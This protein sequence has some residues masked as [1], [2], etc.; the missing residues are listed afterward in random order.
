MVVCQTIRQVISCRRMTTW[1]DVRI[2][3][4][5]TMW[6][7]S[8]DVKEPSS[9]WKLK[10]L[11]ADHSPCRCLQYMVQIE[12]PSWVSVHLVRHGKFAEHFVSSQRNDR[13]SKYDRN[14]ARQDSPVIH[15]IMLNAPEVIFIS[16]R[17]LCMQA[18]TETRDIWAKVV[19]EIG[20]IDPEVE[21]LCHPPCWWYGGRCP[22]MKPCGMCK[23]FNV[24]EQ[25]FRFKGEVDSWR[26][27]YN[28]P[29]L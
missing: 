11:L 15:T 16:K 21:E 29:I 6:K 9:D 2:A 24:M 28:P 10:I 5:S 25:S 4:R 14:A 27:T 12:V 26:T 23:P 1:N 13:Q 18:S 3:A 19:K 20:K 7:L 8:D 22:E 17:R